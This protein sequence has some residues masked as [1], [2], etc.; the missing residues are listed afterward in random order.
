M[1]AGRL[2]R[3][4]GWK[5]Q[6]EHGTVHVMGE[7]GNTGHN[8]NLHDACGRVPGRPRGPIPD[9]ALRALESAAEGFKW[10]DAWVEANPEL[11]VGLGGLH[12]SCLRIACLYTSSSY[13][14]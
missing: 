5:L 11:Q 12:R 8:R 7:L 13:C 10:V 3:G 2:S 14:S 6:G 4:G 9:L 1:E